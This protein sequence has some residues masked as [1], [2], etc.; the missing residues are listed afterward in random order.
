MTKVLDTAKAVLF[1]VSFV[2][3][4]WL[5]LTEPVVAVLLGITGY[6]ALVLAFTGHLDT[7]L[8]SSRRGIR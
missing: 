7:R 5:L 6:I 3:V 1:M 2:V 4:I 8:P